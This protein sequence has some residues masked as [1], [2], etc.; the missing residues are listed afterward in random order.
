MPA[1]AG[2][3]PIADHDVTE[4]EVLQRPG[5]RHVPLPTKRDERRIWPPPARPLPL[6]A[7]GPLPARLQYP[8]EFPRRDLTA[9][10]GSRRRVPPGAGGPRRGA[11]GATGGR[12]TQA[13]SGRRVEETASTYPRPCT[14]RIANT[15]TTR[16][17]TLEPRDPLALH[18]LAAPNALPVRPPDCPSPLL[19][20]AHPHA[21][22][23]P[24]CRRPAS[25][26]PA[27]RLGC[28]ACPG[29]LW[30]VE[31]GGSSAKRWTPLPRKRRRTAE[32]RPEAGRRPGDLL[33]PPARDHQQET[34]R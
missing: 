30:Q 9:P 25:G 23:H 19:C 8:A 18:D 10:A 17:T 14:T 13:T 4:G 33:R 22:H 5:R 20:P 21:R 1:V 11:V 24:A 32:S 6:V 16:S 31:E 3:R 34:T 15:T 7:R 28:P 27:S 12:H 26:P 2:D 29:F